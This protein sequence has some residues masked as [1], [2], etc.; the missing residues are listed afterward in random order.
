MVSNPPYVPEDAYGSLPR[1]VLADPPLA[2]VGGVELSERLFA[3]ARIVL[4]PGGA[5]VV[6][7]EGSQADEICA[8]ASAAGFVGI[9]V[10]HDLSGRD[11]VV[12]A[13]VPR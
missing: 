6:E 4:R 7:I 2:L 13:R 3:E 10:A 5:A 12:T 8:V 9:E 11:R 1:E